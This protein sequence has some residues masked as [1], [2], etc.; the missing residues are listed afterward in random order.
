LHWFR[1]SALRASAPSLDFASLPTKNRQG[2]IQACTGEMLQSGLD[3]G[4]LHNLEDAAVI[5]SIVDKE[6]GS[7]SSTPS[8]ASRAQCANSPL[9]SQRH[10]RLIIE[11]STITVYPESKTA[12]AKNK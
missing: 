2:R 12:G 7:S 11:D 9:S 8:I 1:I 5:I 3:D 10:V 4:R 6:F